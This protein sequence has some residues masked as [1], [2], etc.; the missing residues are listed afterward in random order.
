MATLMAI[1]KSQI[2]MTASGAALLLGSWFSFWAS[3]GHAN[4]GSESGWHDRNPMTL[5]DRFWMTLS[6]NYYALTGLILLAVALVRTI[7]W[8][9]ERERS[10][11]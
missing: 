7:I 8:A 3:L 5:W 11:R 10:L 2:I 9:Y 4:L 1:R 6:P